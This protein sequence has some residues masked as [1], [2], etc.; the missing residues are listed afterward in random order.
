MKAIHIFLI[1]PLNH[2]YLV[3]IV[4]IFSII[5]NAYILNVIEKITSKNCYQGL[6]KYVFFHEISFIK[7]LYIKKELDLNKQPS[8]L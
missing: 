3:I 8:G 5:N 6:K 4:R 7:S 2:H 1:S